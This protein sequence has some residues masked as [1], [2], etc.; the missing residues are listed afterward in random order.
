MKL[1]QE[2]SKDLNEVEVTSQILGFKWNRRPVANSRNVLS[3]VECTSRI[4]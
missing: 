3:E 2:L 1:R 4:S